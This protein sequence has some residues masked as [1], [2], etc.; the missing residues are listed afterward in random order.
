MAMKKNEVLE[1]IKN[2]LDLKSKKEAGEVLNTIDAVI[3]VLVD[4]LDA[5]EKVALGNYIILN[6]KSFPR[7][8]GVA[9]GRHWVKE[10]REEIVLKRSVRLKR[11]LE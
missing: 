4:A 3:E 2:G 10:P 8:E 5:G 1:V 9:M 7:Q 11:I 6:K